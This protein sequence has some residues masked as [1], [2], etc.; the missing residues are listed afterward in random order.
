SFIGYIIHLAIKYPDGIGVTTR[1][2]IPGPKGVPIFGNLFT[3]TFKK[4]TYLELE[5]EL[6]NKYG[7]LYTITIPKRGRNII[8]NDPQTIEY[9]LK[10]KFENFIKDTS[11]TQVYHDLLGDAIFV[12]EG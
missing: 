12:A 6:A 8:S 2:D 4:N 9:V 7:S 3:V 10:T 5:Q 11:F 1:K